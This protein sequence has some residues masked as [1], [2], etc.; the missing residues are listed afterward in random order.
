M[1]IGQQHYFGA[2]GQTEIH[3]AALVILLVAG[4]ML[5]VLPRKYVFIPLLVA[6]VFI[7]FDQ[8]VMLGSIHLTLTRILIFMAWIRVLTMRFMGGGPR[9][10]R[11]TALDTLFATYYAIGTVTFYFLWGDVGAI[12][13][14]V[15]MLYNAIGI[16]FFMRYVVR[17]SRDI[18]RATKTFAWIMLILAGFTLNEQFTGRNI[19]SMFGGVPEHTEVRDGRTRSQGPFAHTLTA[20][21]MGATAVPLLIGLW[22]QGKKNWK[23][24]LM[25]AAAATIVAF[26]S[27][28]STPFIVVAVGIFAL[29]MWSLRRYLKWFRW[30]TVALL[31]SMHLVMKAP[32]WALI[33]RIDLTGSSSSYHR[34]ELVDQ[35]IHRFWEWCL[36]GTTHTSE[37]GWDMWDTINSYV[38]AGTDGGLIGFLLFLAILTTAFWQLGKAR[39]R[40]AASPEHARRVW[41]FGSLLFAHAVAF[42]GIGYFDQSAVVWHAQLAMIATV[43]ALRP[44]TKTKT[45]SSSPAVEDDNILPAFETPVLAG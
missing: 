12:V 1:Q 22:W 36:L 16:Y 5:L 35:F 40:W 17:D 24:A 39:R 30:A 9:M 14:R 32:V 11:W 45:Q 29:C 37:W 21:T 25:G 26:S 43:I 8:Q 31:L 44:S 23:T 6:A 7:P 4:I 2:A 15:G 19:F 18:D 10:P 33:E 13:N 41:V 34:Y 3:P 38:A 20:G 27:M 42:F 28:S